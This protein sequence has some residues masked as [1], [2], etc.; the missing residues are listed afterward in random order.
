MGNVT[1][2]IST[3]L[4][5]FADAQHV[6]V[7]PEF[8]ALTHSLMEK[9]EVAAFG[10]HTFEIFQERWPKRLEDKNS[11]EWIRKMAQDL[12][13]MPKLVFSSTLNMTTWNKSSIVPALDLEYITAFK[14]NNRG[15]FLTFG[16]ISLIETLTKMNVVD[17]YYFNVQPVLSGKGDTRFFSKFNLETPQALKYVDSKQQASGAHILH[18]KNSSAQ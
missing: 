9:A 16:S 7:D 14:K 15:S 3:T 13:D 2:L 8:F 12:H 6:I 17:D 18:Y 5:G 10:R 11:P 4:D 1:V